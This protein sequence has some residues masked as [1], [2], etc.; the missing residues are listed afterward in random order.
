LEGQRL[1]LSS[2]AKSQDSDCRYE[3]FMTGKQKIA[4][5]S[6]GIL[7]D[8]LTFVNLGG[9]RKGFLNALSLH[10]TS[11]T[12]MAPVANWSHSEDLTLWLVPASK[13]ATRVTRETAQHMAKQPSWAVPLY[14]MP[15]VKGHSPEPGKTRYAHKKGI[16]SYALP[17]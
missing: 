5:H 15:P 14:V 13:Y 8:A 9:M 11:E 16:I 4:Y 3:Q 12:E 6:R 1:S 10:L 17:R 2:L 7:S